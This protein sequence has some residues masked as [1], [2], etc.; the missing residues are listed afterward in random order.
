ML[1]NDRSTNN[2]FVPVILHLEE[3]NQLLYKL[4]TMLY[5]HVVTFEV[6]LPAA[7]E[8]FKFSKL[9]AEFNDKI[10]LKLITENQT[11]QATIQISSLFNLIAFT[12]DRKGLNARK[13]LISVGVNHKYESEIFGYRETALE[14]LTKIVTYVASVNSNF[15]ARLEDETGEI[16][17]VTEE[18]RQLDLLTKKQIPAINEIT[19]LDLL[20]IVRC[21][22]IAT[23]QLMIEKENQEKART[24]TDKHQAILDQLKL[25]PATK[26]QLRNVISSSAVMMQRRLNDLF[27]ARL[28]GKKGKTSLAFY[29]LIEQENTPEVLNYKPYRPIVPNRLCFVEAMRECLNS[30][31]QVWPDSVHEAMSAKY[32]D[33]I[34]LLH[35]PKK[36]TASELTQLTVQFYMVLENW[37]K[38]LNP[39]LFSNYAKLTTRFLLLWPDPKM[40]TI[41][42]TI[43]CNSG[44]AIQ[45][46]RDKVEQQGLVQTYDRITRYCRFLYGLGMVRRRTT[47][48]FTYYSA[49]EVSDFQ[50]AE[51]IDLNDPNFGDAFLE[52]NLRQL[53]DTLTENP[54]YLTNIVAQE[55]YPKQRYNCYDTSII[56]DQLLLF[57]FLTK[58]V[59]LTQ[60]SGLYK[61]TP[62]IAERYSRKSNS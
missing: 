57:G 3:V 30:G 44:A 41:L 14:L 9:F 33:P 18:F 48:T 38:R 28:I 36:W 55:K 58:T 26:S 46:L 7:S 8:Y 31:D 1:E 19:T 45:E 21:T 54:E 24:L 59:P 29:Y 2:K 52:V 12:S 13:L 47:C 43:V 20:H 4:Y 40:L 37:K 34:Q 35:L 17:D 49:L 15:L 6:N 39:E 42:D 56:L 11:N 32:G 60:N 16:T 22:E 51:T 61:M 23:P 62:A 27:A 25:G 5:K 53:L 50:W 10:N